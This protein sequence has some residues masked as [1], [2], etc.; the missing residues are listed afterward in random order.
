M[1]ELET[2]SKAGFRSVEIWIDSFQEY[3][4]TNTPAETRRRIGDLGLR[5]ENAIG[6]APWIVD[7]AS[8]RQKGVE[9]LKREM[10]QLAEIGCKRIATP[11]IG[12][13]TPNDPIIPLPPIAERYRAILDMGSQIGVI[14]QLELWGFARNLNRLSDVMYVAIESGHPAARVLLDIY[15]L[16]KGGSGVEMLP[17]V[18]K[19]AIEIFHVN[20]YP[21]NLSREK[22]TDA[23]RIYPGDGIAPIK[24][25]LN[26]IRS[27]GRTVVLSLEVFNK[28]YYAQD[29]QTVAKTAFVKMNRLIGNAD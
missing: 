4:K 10:A 5:V 9:Q 12:A 17:F 3:L 29:A 26:A 25:A 18:G 22:I 11:P 16:Y 15:H 27:P 19:P 21:G 23:D 1:G 2:A 6:F 20:D 13:H 28:S 8:A 14:P 24:A 7:D